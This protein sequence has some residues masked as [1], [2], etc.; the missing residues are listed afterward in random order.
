MSSYH[1]ISDIEA[2]IS[3]EVIAAFHGCRKHI[4]PELAKVTKIT[5]K[6]LIKESD[7]G[8]TVAS[9]RDTCGLQD[10]TRKTAPVP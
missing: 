3:S 1:L 9:R 5:A 10:V 4:A 7:Q 8:D 6:R 2:H